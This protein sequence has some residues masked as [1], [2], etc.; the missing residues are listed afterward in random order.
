MFSKETY[1]SRR[2][3]LKGMLNEG[4]LLFLGNNEAPCNY[5][6][7]TYLFRQDSTFL[8]YFGIDKPGFAAVIDLESG[9]ETIFGNDVDMDDII[10]MGPQPS[11]SEQA[12]EVGVLDTAPFCKL[13][14]VLKE[15]QA[16]GRR[17]HFTPQYRHDNTIYLHQVLGIGFGQEKEAASE[18]LTKAVSGMRLIKE[19]CEI[20][21]IDKA[22][23]LGYAMHYTAMKM[24]RLGM[25]EQELVGVME[26]VCQSEGYM[27]SFATIL[28][29]HGET[30]HNHAH[31]GIITDGKLL[32][33]DAGVEINSHYCS[34]NTRTWPCSGKFTQQ[35]KDIYTIV[36]TANNYAL[37]NARPGVTYRDIHLGASRII[38]QGLKNLGLLHG[39]VEEMVAAGVQGLFMPHGL[40]HNM[41]LDVHD[42]ENLGEDTV[43]Y[44]PDQKRSS[45]LGLGSLRMARSLKAGHVITDEP[46]IYFIPALIQQWKKE[47]HNAQFIDFNRLESYYDFGGI[48]L[49]DDLLITSGGARLLGSK[50]LPITAQE[51]EEEMSQRD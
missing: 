48:R 9:K 26:G 30:M 45:Q 24:M 20:E 28:S 16:K 17:I 47:G 2:Q 34:D 23:N 4:I 37:E 3:R 15:A 39:D 7:N 18:D 49:E 25:K 50:R 19:P 27:C 33:I 51:V 41:G 5:P 32:L 21:E 22:C 44:D 14:N 46:G 10:W 11:V 38:V 6:D 42:M 29:Q 13:E 36:C 40:G 1:V 8:Y 35:Q 31:E 43:G 12:A